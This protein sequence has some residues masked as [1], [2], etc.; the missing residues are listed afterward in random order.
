MPKRAAP[1][2]G[3]GCRAKPQAGRG[4]RWEATKA[5]VRGAAGAVRDA[6]QRHKGWIEPV[7]RWAV[8]AAAAYADRMPVAERQ[9][10]Q[11]APP[12]RREPPP[13]AY[14]PGEPPPYETQQPPPYYRDPPSAPPRRNLEAAGRRRRAN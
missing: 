5:R 2:G 8:R 6:Y 10:P 14:H 11:R 4:P 1:Q 7:G 12:V 9:G 13:P 3:K